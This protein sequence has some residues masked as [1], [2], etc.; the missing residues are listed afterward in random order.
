M[1]EVRAVESGFQAKLDVLAAARTT[2]AQV[3]TAIEYYAARL[4]LAVQARAAMMQRNKALEHAWLGLIPEEE[5]AANAH[6][7]FKARVEAEVRSNHRQT[8]GGTG[9]NASRPP[10]TLPLCPRP[11]L[12]PALAQ[13]STVAQ[14]AAADEGLD[15]SFKDRV[16]G[17]CGA[18]DVDVVTT[19]V[20]LFR[21]RR[22]TPAPQPSHPHGAAVGAPVLARQGS[23]RLGSLAAKPGGGANAPLTRDDCPEGYGSLA[24]HPTLWPVL[25]KLRTEKLDSEA[26]LAAAQG[27]LAAMKVHLTRLAGTYETLKARI[28]AIGAE[29][30]ELASA[31]EVATNDVELLVR[32]KHGQVRCGPRGRGAHGTAAA[33]ILAWSSHTCV[34]A[35]CVPTP[36]HALSSRTR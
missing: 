36:P 14:L 4:G 29:R 18:L 32:L 33:V 25:N 6:E 3:T 26:A 31:R 13:A 27:R 2:I 21:L 35:C 7:E 30:D 17:A 9:A 5:E 20:R 24:D 11:L 28:D 12:T 10:S 15:R 22:A 16:K 1:G 8:R 23:V 19:A 34:R